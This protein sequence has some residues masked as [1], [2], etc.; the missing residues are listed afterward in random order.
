M[1][2]RLCG[3]WAWLDTAIDVHA[4]VA[5]IGGASLAAAIALNGFLSLFPLLLVGISVVGVFSAGD[6]SFGPD[7]IDRIGLQGDSAG[8]FTDALAAAESSRRAASIVG[9]VGLA[10]SGLGVVGSLQA[11]TNAAWQVSGRGLVDK[12]FGLLWLL[13]AAVLFSAS[14]AL[15][16]AAGV[17]PGIVAPLFVLGGLGVN[18]V[19]FVWTFNVLGNQSPGW[20]A[21]LPGALLAALGFEIL[22]GAGS[23]VL[24]Q[25]VA[26]S[27]ALYGSIGVVF[28]VLAWLVLNARLIIYAICLN[29][30]R[31]EAGA[32]TVTVQIEVPRVEGDVPLEAGRGGAVVERQPGAADRDL[33]SR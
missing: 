26:S 11:A 27:S 16:A 18:V 5:A 29:V 3:R 10:W 24:S 32:G 19:L 15:G 2:K 7:L 17:L 23:L 4:R 30:V 25:S 9:I 33:T 28:A 1:L 31:Y 6:T 13:G 14:L 22:K 8:V 21:F 20:R 12:A